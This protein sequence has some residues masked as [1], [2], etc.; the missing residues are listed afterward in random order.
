MS[1][2]RSGRLG[3]TSHV[4]GSHLL[5]YSADG[6]FELLNRIGGTTATAWAGSIAEMNCDLIVWRSYRGESG[7]GVQRVLLKRPLFDSH[8]R[9]DFQYPGNR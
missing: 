4:G 5:Q 1:T 7:Y 3:D 8:R 2:P 9:P 6:L